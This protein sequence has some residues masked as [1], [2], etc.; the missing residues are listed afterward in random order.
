MLASGL[1]ET[2]ND[3]EDLARFL[4]SS[5]AFNT[6]MVKPSAFLPSPRDRETSVFRHGR[7][8]KE[9]LWAIGVEHV[10]HAAAGRTLHGAAIVKAREVRAALLDVTADE[11]PPRHAVIRGWP[12]VANDPELQKAQQKERANSIA[13]KATLLLLHS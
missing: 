13:S 11:P 2:V 1:P 7:E 4:T 12:Y 3:D 5:G 6:Q 8:P 10:E 9:T